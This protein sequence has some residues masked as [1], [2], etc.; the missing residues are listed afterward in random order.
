VNAETL[1][2]VYEHAGWEVDLA[3]RELRRNGVPIA[4]GGRAF[5]IIEVLVRSAGRLVSKAE[6]MAAVWPGARVEENT[7]QVYV[8][9][10][11]KALGA[12]RG[13]L[14]T[15]SGRGYRLAGTWGPHEL[16]DASE[17]VAPAP[18]APTNLPILVTELVGRVAAAEQLQRLIPGR[19]LVTLTGAGGIGKTS[20]ALAVARRLLPAFPGG[21]WLVELAS[22]SDP[23]LVPSTVGRAMG[24]K[25]VGGE[26]APETL[27]RSIGMSKL[28]L[29]LDN[30]E[31]LIDA[32]ARLVET[33]IRMCPNASVLA[34]SR[35]LL[36]I[37]G[38]HVYRVPP[39]DVPPEQPTTHDAPL[40]HS[41]VQLF[42]TRV[43]ATLGEF[44]PTRASLQAIGAICRHLDGLPLAIEFAAARAAMIGPGLVLEHLGER[45]A[46]LTGG[47]RT[48]LP[49]HRTLRA[50]LDWSYELLSEAERRLLR[51]LSIFAAGF[52]VEAAA[53]VLADSG[54]SAYAV[55]EGIGNLAAKSLVAVEGSMP[56]GRW[57]LLETIRAYALEKLGETGEI[58]VA[59][60]RHAQYFRDLLLPAA[61][62]SP[63]HFTTEM[64]ARYRLEID[65]VRAAIDWAFSACGDTEI[66]ITLTAAYAPVWLNLALT[67]ECRERTEHALDKVTPDSKL[68]ER[69]LMQLNLEHGVALKLTQGSVDRIRTDLAKAL[70][71]AERL[72]DVN[73]Q[74]RVLWSIWASHFVAGHCRAMQSAAEGFLRTAE[75]SGDRMALLF[76]DRMIGAG[77]VMSGDPVA[78]QERFT[79]VVQS[80]VT[81]EIQQHTFWAQLDQA[82]L[83]RAMLAKALCLQGLADQA[84]AHARRSLDE[85][86]AKDNKHVECEVLRLAVCPLAFILGDRAAAE[87]GVA[88]YLEVASSINSLTYTVIGETLEGKLLLMRGEF[89]RGVDTLR[90][91]LVTLESAGWTQAFPELLGALSEGEAELGRGAEALATL[92]RALRLA[93]ESGEV[94]YSPEL[95]RLEGEL[96]LQMDKSSSNAAAVA[97]FERG[98]DLARKQKSLVWELR[99]ALSLAQHRRRCGRAAHARKILEPVLARFDEGHE[100]AALRTAR[101]ILSSL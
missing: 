25:P 75:R 2:P 6:L 36:R 27:G 44:D 76:A 73:G 94:W 11:R 16:R 93:A 57:R 61:P 96:L 81:P 4:L 95:L 74:L 78:A 79:R 52:T 46:F 82:I 19:Q 83:A 35:E 92:E 28:L 84:T 43:R 56:G 68:N 23:K 71:I 20:L 50:A 67:S 10:V 41:A 9:A 33:L 86:R 15:S 34:T 100:T 60:R 58:E 55:A 3:R 5:D 91:A 70:E 77:L 37:V 89:A 64:L 101:S 39:L 13:I 40:D 1:L 90:Q 21:T 32:T 17:P 59:A 45:F 26:L 62:S 38:E 97:C 88:A 66:G 47:H 69:L 54:L 7:L 24:L 51:R 8:S 42:V 29:V 53:A 22:L 14:K 85:A 72:D 99:I 30:C 63:A 12:D 65:N 31:H 98:L 18:M 87:H 48:A 49:R 80:Y